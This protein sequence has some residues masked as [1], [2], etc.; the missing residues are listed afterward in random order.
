MGLESA[1]Y[2]DG[3]NASNPVHATDPV[4]Q[5]DDHVRLLKSVLLN[6]F[7]NLDAAVDLT[8]TEMNHLDGVTGVTG[9]GALVLAASPTVTG[10]F[11]AAAIEATT[12]DGIAAANLV[13]KSAAETIGGAWD[14]DV[15]TA[16]SYDGVVAANLVDKSAAETIAGNW[17]FSATLTLSEIAGSGGSLD[18]G[19]TNITSDNDDA[20]EPGYKGAPQRIVNASESLVLTDA[21]LQIYKA[22]G[23]AGETITIPANVSIAFP[24]GTI[25]EIVNDGGGDLSIAIATDTL[26]EWFTGY[27]GTRTLPDN[28][29]AIIE[30]IAATFWKYQ[31]TG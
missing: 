24:I 13:D 22:S 14:F 11:T 30:K 10:T 12:Y 17:E 20:R 4:S 19:S 21:G 5:G 29:K 3:L 31:A 15:L 25:I 1:T 6:T 26:E 7:P 23:G 18:F 8:P 9:S 16:T 27:T 2:I 28:N